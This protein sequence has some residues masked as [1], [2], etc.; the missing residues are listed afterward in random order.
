M[1]GPFFGSWSAAIIQGRKLFK[2]GNYCFITIFD[3]SININLC[4]YC[5]KTLELATIVFIL[6]KNFLFLGNMLYIYFNES[7]DAICLV[8]SNM[9]LELKE[10]LNC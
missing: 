9:I 4:F 8:K 6:H 10:K 1:D 5:S 2:G 7:I 3:A